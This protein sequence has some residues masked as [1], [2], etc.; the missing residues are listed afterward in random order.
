MDI[1]EEIITHD[2]DADKACSLQPKDGKS[3]S[4]QMTCPQC[5]QAELDYD[6]LLNLHCPA[7]G[8]VSAG[9]FT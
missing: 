8:Y 1:W 9:S 4:R 7:C 6:A 3:F 2:I 5:G